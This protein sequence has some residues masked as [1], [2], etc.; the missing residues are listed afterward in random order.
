MAKKKAVSKK[1]FDI[2]AEAKKLA[3][4][5]FKNLCKT[6]LSNTGSI[7]GMQ[8]WS[9][10]W[11]ISGEDSKPIPKRIEVK[12][13]DIWSNAEGDLLIAKTDVSP[14]KSIEVAVK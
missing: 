7:A 1:K 4:K 2:Q 14:E 13:Q 12:W 11:E 3:P 9:K 8:A 10:V 6:A 5:L